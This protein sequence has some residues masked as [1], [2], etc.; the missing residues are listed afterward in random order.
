MIY[1]LQVQWLLLQESSMKKSIYFYIYLSFVL[2]CYL[3]LIFI[4]VQQRNIDILS[5]NKNKKVH[6]ENIF[7]ETFTFSK[8]TPTK[9][10]LSDKQNVNTSPKQ[11][12][13]NYN[14]LSAK[15]EKDSQSYDTSDENSQIAEEK[16]EK[17]KKE[18]LT[19]DGENLPTLFDISKKPAI[20]MDNQGNISL[21]SIEYE[22]ASYFLEIQKRVGENWKTFFPVFQYYQGIIKSG[23]VIVNFKIDENGNVKDAVVL[24]SYGYSILDQSCLNAVIYSKNFGQLPEGLKKEAPISINFKFIYIAR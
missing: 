4:V 20:E 15:K 11:G 22:H 8:E 21:G 14:I 9:A 18:N 23:E 7:V 24:K 5:S 6:I 2:H 17:K 13:N 3:A 12:E 16:I 19:L 1:F 10:V